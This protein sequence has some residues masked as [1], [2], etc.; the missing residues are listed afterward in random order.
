MHLR[1]LELTSLVPGLSLSSPHPILIPSS[2]PSSSPP[3]ALLCDQADPGSNA[4]AASKLP[5][6]LRGLDLTSL[7]PGLSSALQAAGGLQQMMSGS[8]DGLTVYV[9]TYVVLLA[10]KA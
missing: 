7:V 5:M 1:G 10:T 2:S 6:H 9:V 8:W 4:A 3:H